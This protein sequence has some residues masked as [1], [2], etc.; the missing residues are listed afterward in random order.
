MK[1]NPNFKNTANKVPS[2]PVIVTAFLVVS[3][4]V[5]VI[6]QNNNTRAVTTKAN[7]GPITTQFN[8]II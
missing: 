2:I 6:V 7:V 4:V 8:P 5:I 3:V 1:N